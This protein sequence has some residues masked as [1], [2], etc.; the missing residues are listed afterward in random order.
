MPTAKDWELKVDPVK[1]VE[2]AKNCQRNFIKVKYRV[3][4]RIVYA[5]CSIRI[6]WEDSIESKRNEYVELVEI[7]HD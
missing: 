3:Y 2:I 5:S 4:L 7:C 6:L 1:V